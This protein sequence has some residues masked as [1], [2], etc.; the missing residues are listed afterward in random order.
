MKTFVIAAAGLAVLTGAAPALIAP[1]AAQ[2]T[3]AREHTVV[4]ERTVVRGP[5]PR[6]AHARKTCSSRW[7]HGHKVRVCRTVR[8][9]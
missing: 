3:V 2:H 5:A 6:V 1:A 8:Y 9:R 4:R 7:H